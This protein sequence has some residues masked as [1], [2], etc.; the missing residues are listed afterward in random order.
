MKGVVRTA[1]GG[2]EKGGRR[3]P[4]SSDQANEAFLTASNSTRGHL[5]TLDLD[6]DSSPWLWW[7]Q[8][9]WCVYSEL[10]LFYRHCIKIHRSPSK[11]P[12]SFSLSFLY[13]LS[14]SSLSVCLF[15]A[16][17]P[18]GYLFS[19]ASLLILP[20]HTTRRLSTV[21]WCRGL[22]FTWVAWSFIWPGHMIR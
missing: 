14:S 6:L 1:R 17:R 2:R 7:R 4:A 11:S 13:S 20:S 22:C 15:P 5:C 18:A 3:G 10:G 8:H 12:L 21:F 16:G 9:C 19:C